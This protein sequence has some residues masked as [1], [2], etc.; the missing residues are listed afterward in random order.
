MREELS[1][2]SEA[3]KCLVEIPVDARSRLSRVCHSE[4]VL[5][6]SCRA[7][8][9]RAIAAIQFTKLV[10][11]KSSSCTFPLRWAWQGRRCDCEAFCSDM[12]CDDSHSKDY[13][14]LTVVTGHNSLLS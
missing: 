12:N 10:N 3:D 8:R 11:T 6:R 7:T 4:G 14:T 9:H 13:F 2:C 5:L 1:V